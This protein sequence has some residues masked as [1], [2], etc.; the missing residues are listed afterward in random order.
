L[1]REG[2]R[3]LLQIVGGHWRWSALGV[4]LTLVA[5]AL[6]LAQPLVVK[7]VIESAADGVTPWQVIGLLI[8][9]FVAQ[10][11]IEFVVRIALART[12][13]GIV[14]S[15]RLN[16]IDHLLRLHM[17]AY[18]R[19]RVGDLISR[20]TNDTTALRKVVAEG[21]TD[22]LTGAVGMVGTLALMLWLDATLFAMVLTLVA[23]GGFM[24]LAVMRGIR[25]AS[26]RT[27]Q[28]TGSLASDLE[29]ALSAIR[30]IRASQAEQRESERIGN[31]AK[32]VY[33]ASF[34]MDKLDA[35]VGP[36][37]SLI[38]NGS[39]LAVLLV[40]GIR[41]ANGSASIAEL[42][43]FVLYL[44]YLTG[45]IGAAFQ[46]LSTIQ[47]GMGALQRIDEALALPREPDVPPGEAAVV[48]GDGRVTVSR[49]DDGGAGEPV[50]EFRDVW[51][52]YDQAR[53]VLRSVSLEIPQRGC[54]AL[55]GLSG[56]GKSTI[57]AL[58]ER[59]YDP[60]D[61]EILFCSEN[62]RALDLRAYRA[63]IGLVEQHVPLL[64]GTLRD[65]LTYTRPNANEHEI[66]RA[67]RLSNLSAVVAQLPR[68]LDSDVG[69]RGMMLS[70]GERQR[71]G[72]ARSLLSRPQ[73]LLL[74]EPTA[75]LD[76]INEAA[77]DRTIEQIS[78]ECG[79]LLIAHRYSTV[80]I[81]DHVVVLHN[82]EVAAT[83]TH[84]ELLDT[85]DYYRRLATTIAQHARA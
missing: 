64:H 17:P 25:R 73:L 55:I 5:L 33:S 19:Q 47:Q 30:T 70:G 23:I 75:H 76:P 59:F 13:E 14:L 78:S 21:L 37:I 71:V 26:L 35:L 65:N 52:G 8:A 77:L 44:T 32:R 18:D 22:A 58:I 10:A 84:E 50:L 60:Q 3:G 39:A 82:G 72:I 43:A 28:A 79:L 80:Q 24:L 62:V 53:P 49:D 38:V 27:Q 57:F 20:A 6:S 46:A 85:S 29:R 11:L 81:A 68:G 1:R 31:E 16:L 83:G 42:V 36:A 48:S 9:L 40:G 69:E 12:G 7:H 67:L 2:L 63:R 66:E 74:D 56:A 51:F 45:P 15:L 54:V 34:A 61:G 4:T 41:V